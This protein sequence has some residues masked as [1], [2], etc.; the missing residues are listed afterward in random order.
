MSNIT[1]SI[2]QSANLPIKIKNKIKKQSK[3]N[4]PINQS[5]NLPIKKKKRKHSANQD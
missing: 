3:N 4:L 1:N 2:Y 5:A